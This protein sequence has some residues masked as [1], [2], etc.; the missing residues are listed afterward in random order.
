MSRGEII[1]S[2]MYVTE[3]IFHGFQLAAAG[4]STFPFTEDLEFFV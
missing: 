2:S 3:R 1:S 4:G